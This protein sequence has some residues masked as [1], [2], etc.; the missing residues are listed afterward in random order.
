MVFNFILYDSINKS[1]LHLK[2]LGPLTLLV[3]NNEMF[4]IDHALD[5]KLNFELRKLPY[6]ISH[7]HS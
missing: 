5:K 1:L 3:N 7:K 6:L 4:R 2:R